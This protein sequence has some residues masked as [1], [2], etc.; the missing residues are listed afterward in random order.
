MAIKTTKQ[1]P[2]TTLHEGEKYILVEPMGSTVAFSFGVSPDGTTM[3]TM[4]ED[5]LQA[6]E[7]FGQAIIDAA[8]MIR[9]QA[10]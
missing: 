10:Q 3:F 1:G 4:N 8:R 9:R 2:S 6:V 5:D 7:A